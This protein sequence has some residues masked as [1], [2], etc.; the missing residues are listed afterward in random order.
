MDGQTREIPTQ[1]TP[2][3]TANR[4]LKMQI[5]SKQQ[6]DVDKN[7]NSDNHEE[8]IHEKQNQEKVITLY[9]NNLL[10]IEN[11]CYFIFKKTPLNYIRNF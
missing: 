3:T 7:S 1:L 11:N 5:F 6:F 9:V 2:S 4:N 8:D 10:I